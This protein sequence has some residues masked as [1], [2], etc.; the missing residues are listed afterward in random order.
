MNTDALAQ[1]SKLAD[2]QMGG[3]FHC[4]VYDCVFT[5]GCPC[6]VYGETCHKKMTVTSM[7]KTK[8]PIPWT[9]NEGACCYLCCCPCICLADKQLCFCHPCVLAQRNR[10][11]SILF[12]AFNEIR[13]GGNPMRGHDGAHQ[14]GEGYGFDGYEWYYRDDEAQQKGPFTTEA[15]QKLYWSPADV[16]TCSGPGFQGIED[17]TMVWSE[18]MEEVGWTKI[19]MYPDLKRV[20]LG[21]TRESN[22]EVHVEVEETGQGQDKAPPKQLDME[23]AVV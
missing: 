6:L 22:I 17:E 23:R 21:K 11:S 19:G 13:Q 12:N 15:L 3:L 18:E 4:G 8:S 14:I 10:Q 7:T 16:G 9:K 1:A 2:E 20:L 5:M